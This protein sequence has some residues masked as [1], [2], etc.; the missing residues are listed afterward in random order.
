MRTLACLLVLMMGNIG[1]EVRSA[2][3]M[4]ARPVDTSEVVVRT[5]ASETLARYRTDPAYSYDTAAGGTSWWDRLWAW[6]FDQLDRA[7]SVPWAEEGLYALA[8]LATAGLLLFAVHWL[9][10]MRRTAPVERRT[11]LSADASVT[12]ETLETADFAAQAEAAEADRAY[13]RAV[14]FY[15]LDLLQRLVRA[16][17]VV[18]TPDKANRELVRETR[19]TPVYDAFARSTTFFERVWY[20]D[21]SLD[22]SSYER[23]RE[24]LARART[25]V[26]ETEP[27]PAP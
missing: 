4:G 26:P 8:V 10:R 5:P 11:S 23:I 1:G 17:L 22:R 9:F 16:D 13:R 7:V 2:S 25:Q 20:G 14:R 18:W 27:H 12:R 15:Y 19:G 21:V 3:A 24:D 6:I